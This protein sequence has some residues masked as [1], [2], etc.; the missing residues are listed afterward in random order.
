MNERDSRLKQRTEFQ[1]VCDSLAKPSTQS[2]RQTTTRRK[3]FSLREILVPTNTATNFPPLGTSNQAG[4]P[5]QQ[6]TTQRT[7]YNAW[8]NPIAVDADSQQDT[9]TDTYTMSSDSQQTIES[10]QNKIKELEAIAEEKEREKEKEK[11]EWERKVDDKFEALLKANQEQNRE[12]MRTM[13]VNMGQLMTN[14]C[15]QVMLQYNLI[16]PT[17]ATQNSYNDNNKAPYSESPTRK[18]GEPVVTRGN[19]TPTRSNQSNNRHPITQ[20][21]ETNS[22]ETMEI[23]NARGRPPGNTP[24][25]NKRPKPLP[26]PSTTAGSQDHQNAEPRSR[27]NT[28]GKELDG[29]GR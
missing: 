20:L 5:Q 6:R 2:K 28:G 27:D 22:R 1:K 23:S 24:D 14:T 18:Q 15:V 17:Q 13:T 19:F 4:A 7:S 29:D 11:K 8:N 10:L 9:L 16:S 25:Q 21:Q 12:M 26:K 3:P